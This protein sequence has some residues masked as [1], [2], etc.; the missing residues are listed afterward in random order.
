MIVFAALLPLHPVSAA[1]AVQDRDRAEAA[2]DTSEPAGGEGGG[3]ADIVVT[4]PRYG[5]AVVAAETEIAEDEIAAQGA[6]S[7][8]ELLERLSPLIDP[9][10]EEPV[11]LVNGED[12][13]F[14]R[15]ILAYPPE[16]LQ[17]LGVLEPG[18]AARYGHPAGKR[19]INLV[20]KKQFARRTVDLAAR[21]PTRGGRHGGDLSIGQVAISGPTRWNVQGRVSFDSALRESAR[22]VRREAVD[23]A[24]YVAALDGGE[25]DPA[26]SAVAGRIV[27]VAPLPG[28]FAGSRPALADFARPRDPASVV[29]AA[30]FANLLPA[31]RNASLNLG[32]GRRIGAFNAA[33]NLTASASESVDHRGL[34]V[35]SAIL[36]A[37]SRWSPFVRDV[38][39]VRPLDGDAALRNE[40]H[41][42]SL[43]LSVSL[44]GQLAG[45]R[46]Q[47]SA[48]YGHNRGRNLRESGIDTAQVQ[49]LLDGDAA[50]FDPYRPWSRRLLSATRN[51]SASDSLSLRINAAKQVFELADA[52]VN[53][54]VTV[55]AMGSES[56]FT[57]L[58]RLGNA[59]PGSSRTTHR[60]GGGE[61]AL[62]I[63]LARRGDAGL[64]PLG[65]LSLDLSAGGRASSGSALRRQYGAGFTW[66]PA[67]FVRLRGSFEHRETAP[68][69]DDLGAPRVETVK[70]LY[71]FV[72]QELAEPLWITGGNPA[73]D[74]G[75]RRTLSLSA[76]LRPLDSLALTL[77]VRYRRREG[78]GGIAPFPELTPA[79]EAAFPERVTRDDAGRLVAV[80]ARAINIA[81]SSE[82]ELVSGVNL[83]LP[84]PS[85]ASGRGAISGRDPLRYTLSINHTW[86]LENELLIHPGAPVIDRLA[87]T[88]QSRHALSARATVGR[89]AIGAN[90]QATWSSPSR[91]RATAAAPPAS[92]FRYRPPLSVDF[93]LFAEPAEFAADAEN[94]GWLA[95][96]RLSLDVENLFDSYRRVTLSDGTV[97]PGF[98]RY[99]ID[100]LGRTVKVSIRKQF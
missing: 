62:D 18:A 94:A 27:T 35:V 11:I 48:V 65:D 13:G 54:S 1:T 15:S 58:D 39:L 41:A 50:G 69:S 30:R 46:T 33:V 34:P 60:R 38:A 79:T 6:A 84:D 98:A 19:V 32:I 95:D 66:S 86:K 64:L 85:A 40:N 42:R 63:P 88:G 26:L 22:D 44:S 28:A 37:D 97:P 4:A 91:V 76:Q 10:G 20:L 56:R 21:A 83:R 82:S 7:I 99:E 5:E 78:Q 52:P 25:I 77:D 55:D 74:R 31:Q 80:D 14:D 57:P 75:S 93:G 90:L 68:S 17:R 49:S 45:W 36:P 9:S 92:D 8:S 59:Q 2:P 23:L 24:G 100:P 12:V 67:S 16:A 87:E 3:D 61:L 72:R 71:D 53:A 47:L 96:L 43:G 29:D 81:R 73:L 70:L 89:K 51:R